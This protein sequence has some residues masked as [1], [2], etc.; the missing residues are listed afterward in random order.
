VGYVLIT[1]ATGGI[2]S[3]FCRQ[4]VLDN[5]LLITGRSED[6]LNA[7]KEELLKLNKNAKIELFSADLT[8][9]E[10]RDELFA[11]A[12]QKGIK[13]SGLINVAGVDTQKEFIKYTHE[14]I[15][16]QIRVNV[17]ST[18]AITHGVLRQREKDLKI[19]TVSSMSGT[20]PMPYFAI[21]SATKATLNSFF[22]S[23]RYEVKDAKIT[24]LMPGAVPTREDIKRDIQLQGL[25]GKLSSK[26]VDFVVKKALKGLEKNKQRV[27]PGAFNKFIYFIE[28]IT[29]KSIQCRYVA[30]KWSKKEKDNFN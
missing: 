8:C 21:Y 18:I 2:G 3:E 20:V 5:D 12:D 7:L 13:F 22:K 11:F 28:K 14:K 17:E 6:K 25:T 24:T 16:F 26:P 30:K 4:L 9:F 15:T 23:L 1:G 27:I 29:P 10:K 19:L